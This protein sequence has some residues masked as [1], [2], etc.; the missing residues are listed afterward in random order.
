MV[1]IK[2]RRRRKRRRRSSRDELYYKSECERST[3]E[4]IGFKATSGLANEPAVVVRPK[5]AW[6]LGCAYL[7]AWLVGCLAC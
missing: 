4:A 7:V 5:S 3:N 1:T 6:L 2:R